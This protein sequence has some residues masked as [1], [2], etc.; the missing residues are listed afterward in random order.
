MT[1]EPTHGVTVHQDVMVE[2]RDGISLATDIYRP[3]DPDTGE[4]ID[5]PRPALLVRTP[6][7]KR[8]RHRIEKQGNWYAKRGYVIAIQDRSW[9]VRERR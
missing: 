6:Y 7:D 5:D 9:P 4:P 3:T 8:E 2:L 1:S